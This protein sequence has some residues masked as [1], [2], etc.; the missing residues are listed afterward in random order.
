M[1]KN[2]FYFAVLTVFLSTGALA[3]APTIKVSESNVDRYKPETILSSK[4]LFKL[5]SG[6]SIKLALADSKGMKAYRL[7]GPH[8]DKKLEKPFLQTILELFTKRSSANDAP[9]SVID[10]MQDEDFCF[11]A[12][13]DTLLLWR[14]HADVQQDVWIR[15]DADAKPVRLLWRDGEA[16]R[17]WPLAKLPPTD[18]QEYFISVA[19]TGMAAADVL[20][21][22][23]RFHV[24]PEGFSTS[25]QEVWNTNA[26]CLR[27]GIQ[28]L[29]AEPSP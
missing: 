28:P 16:T 25:E 6:E 1:R 27:Q 2:Y 7:S 4:T 18:G 17:Q 11:S 13:V 23:L 9:D 15:K 29:P 26:G 21:R 5:E 22:P 20:F 3:Q 19:D 12:P 8:S 10:A 14:A 24:V